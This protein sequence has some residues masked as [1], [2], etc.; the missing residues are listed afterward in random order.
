MADVYITNM[1]IMELNI[2]DAQELI[3]LF[4][5]WCKSKNKCKGLK[6][7]ITVMKK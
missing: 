1:N 5:G 7:K 6:F 2:K 4:S 3:C